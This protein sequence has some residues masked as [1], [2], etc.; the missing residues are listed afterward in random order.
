M[1]QSVPTI[2]NLASEPFRRERAQNAI[3]AAACVLLTCSLL[4]L[5]GLILNERAQVNDQ[6]REID[7]RTA[8]VARLQQ[9]QMRSSLILSK[10]E[11]ADVF[12][13]SVFLNQLISRRGVS[14]LRIFEDLSQVMPPG[15][16][17]MAIRL[18]QLGSP[19]PR[20]NRLQL[21]MLLGSDQPETVIEFLRHLDHSALF[22]APSVINEQAP[23]Q[24]DPFF[25]FRMTV[26][27]DQKL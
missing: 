10:P 13:T 3:Y 9:E 11:N 23:T 27:Y 18:P 12:S 8:E 15:M 16:K 19:E 24:N 6:R 14:W 22:G 26:T 2:I 25:R 7:A 17:L 4:V 5:T 20:K 21:D 1:T